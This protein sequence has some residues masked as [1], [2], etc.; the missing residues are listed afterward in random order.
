[1]RRFFGVIA[2]AGM[3]AG[4]APAAE[5]PT[6]ALD[7]LV[8]GRS[9]RAEVEAALGAPAYVDR[10]GDGRSAL[11][12]DYE[13]AA[14]RRMTVQ[15]VLDT[16]GVLQARRSYVQGA[17]ER[18][19]SATPGALSAIGGF[20]PYDAAGLRR[21]DWTAIAQG[22]IWRCAVLGA[23]PA[24]GRSALRDHSEDFRAGYGEPEP[25]EGAGWGAAISHGAFGERAFEPDVRGD[26]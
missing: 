13:A 24:V 19:P 3:I 10:I 21:L 12:Y 4:A 2:A 22:P 1:M 15:L 6:A 17:G 20:D 18:A 7:A 8:S 23:R 9:S 16:R 5:P 11:L 14:H 25:A 26:P